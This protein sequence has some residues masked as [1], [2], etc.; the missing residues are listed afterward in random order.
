MG[1][2]LAMAPAGGNSVSGLGGAAMGGHVPATAPM[3]PVG[4]VGLGIGA[5][6]AIGPGMGALGGALL[7]DEP[8]READS[9]LLAELA[10]ERLGV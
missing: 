5:P 1:G 2:P 7:L 10:G 8:S 4:S 9:R 6:P 3:Q